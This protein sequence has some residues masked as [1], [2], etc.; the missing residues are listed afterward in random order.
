ML[1][2]ALPPELAP[3]PVPA[4]L[5]PPP[6]GRPPA[7]G[8]TALG[9]LPGLPVGGGLPGLPAG[10]G[11]AGVAELALALAAAAGRLTCGIL[12]DAGLGGVVP[13]PL[14]V[15]AGGL[16]AE[17]GEELGA[18]EFA[19]DDWPPCGVPEGAWPDAAAPGDGGFGDCDAWLGLL[20]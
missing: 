17:A 12:V 4:P 13:E 8:D 16:A 10:G 7:A 5:L 9:P 19:G 2:P 18:G 3:P 15:G 20:P 14:A 1:R 11:L 6:G